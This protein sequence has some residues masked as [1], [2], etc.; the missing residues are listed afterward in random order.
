M[1]I[2]EDFFEYM[3]NNND[4]QNL[5][6]A[7]SSEKNLVKHGLSETD[8]R[9]KIKY[10][11]IKHGFKIYTQQSFVDKIF[12]IKK[13]TTGSNMLDDIIN[14]GVESGTITEIFGP[15]GS[16]KTQ[17]CMQLAANNLSNDTKQKTIYIDTER[18]FHISRIIQICDSLNLNKN[19][20]LKNI[21]YSKENTVNGLINKL[22]KTEFFLQNNSVSLIIIDN[23]IGPFKAESDH[24]DSDLIRV[25]IHNIMSKLLNY[26]E[27]Y[28]CAIVLSNRVYS[29]PDMLIN[30]K[31]SHFGGLTLSSYIHK[32]IYLKKQ[33]ESI[34]Y[35]KNTSSSKN[36]LFKIN[37]NGVSDI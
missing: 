5:W 13:I 30:N 4:F 20:I 6:V 7:L 16:G 26:I 12:K 31:I 19:L 27:K 36:T 24:F 8:A 17:I 33:E 18:G 22:N 29:I 9:Q 35:A 2:N 37:E 32:Q 3:K 25:S 1:S 11:Q 15:S 23:I 14:N 28:N 21:L 34:F 10:A